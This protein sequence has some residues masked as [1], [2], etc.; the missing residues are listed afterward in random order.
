MN[1]T[2][3][4]QNDKNENFEAEFQQSFKSERPKNKIKVNDLPYDSPQSINSLITK[5]IVHN[6]QANLLKVS[7]VKVSGVQCVKEN[8]KYYLY[9]NNVKGNLYAIK[10]DSGDVEFAEE[11][12]KEEEEEQEEEIVYKYLKISGEKYILIDSD[13]YTISNDK[14]HE[15]YGQ[16]INKK[17]TKLH[18]EGISPSRLL[19]KNDKIIVKGRTKNKN[20]DDLEAELNS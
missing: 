19:Q 14:P 17:F 2:E 12:E 15:L 7:V 13:V 18:V 10:N 11:Q 6:K 16:Y 5:N 3:E 4:I 1:I 20:L 8:N 9:E